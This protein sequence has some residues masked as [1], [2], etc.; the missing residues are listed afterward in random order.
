MSIK[1]AESIKQTAEGLSGIVLNFHGGKNIEIDH[2]INC[3][4]FV[5]TLTLNRFTE[6]NLSGSV[7]SLE[8][9]H[10]PVLHFQVS[11]KY[12]EDRF[13]FTEECKYWN[14]GCLKPWPSIIH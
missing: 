1:A 11:G 8:F 10:G 13:S 3:G 12:D 2:C 5:G 6:F 7:V 4:H 14:C 9:K